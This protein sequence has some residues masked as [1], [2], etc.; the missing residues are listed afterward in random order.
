MKG[1][2]DSYGLKIIFSYLGTKP[3]PF[4]QNDIERYTRGSKTR[5]FQEAILPRPSCDECLHGSKM[6]AV[7]CVVL[8]IDQ[9]LQKYN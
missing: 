6:K 5:R 9:K 8:L 1:F 3:P 2:S 7:A 4:D